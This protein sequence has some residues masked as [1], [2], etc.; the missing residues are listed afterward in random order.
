MRDYVPILRILSI[1]TPAE[2]AAQARKL[3]DAGYRYLKIKLEGEVEDDVDRVRAIRREVG[4]GC[5]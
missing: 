1:K 5:G 2:M 3:I 4:D